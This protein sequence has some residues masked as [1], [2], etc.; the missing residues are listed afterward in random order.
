MMMMLE[1]LRMGS[2]LVPLAV[3]AGL[4]QLVWT[5]PAEYAANPRIRWT[6]IGLLPIS[7]SLLFSNFLLLKQRPDISAPFK[8]SLG[9]MFAGLFFKSF[10]LAFNQPSSKNASPAQDRLPPSVLSNFINILSLLLNGS[11]NPSKQCRLVTGKGD[12]TIRADGVFLISTIGRMVFL[13]SLGVVG[14]CIWQGVNDEVL[15]SRYP[16]LER[17]QSEI[18]TLVWGVFPWTSIDLAGCLSRIFLLVLKSVN[19]LLSNLTPHQHPLAKELSQTDLEQT[20]PFHFQK[21][22]FT[23][24]SVIGFWTRHWHGL[25]RDLV[26]EA[27]TIP[28]TFLVVRAFGARQAHPKFLRLCGILAAFAISAILHEAG[29]WAVGSFDWRLRTS[30]F[31]MSQGVGVCF[32]NAFK[33]FTGRA[34]GGPLGRLW[35]YTWL[36]LFGTP[37]VSC[38]ISHVGFEQ[39][40]I[41]AHVSRLGFWKM[42]ATP[43]VLAQLALSE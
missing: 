6:R 31:F 16:I 13:N 5:S 20:C 34:V 36:V 23:A 10:L 33:H 17:Y 9:C 28:V 32:E 42:L 38:W 7:L 30:V 22:P 3:Q 14:L 41:L 25:I 26:I 19:R 21:T 1:W 11:S 15:L 35:T 18:T 12:H 4:L 39:H 24:S 27:G 40:R 29:I 43:F 8:V 37:M 2:H